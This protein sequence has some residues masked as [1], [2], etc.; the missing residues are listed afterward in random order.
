VRIQSASF[1]FAFNSAL[2]RRVSYP[3]W[4]RQFHPS[5]EGFRAIIQ[6]VHAQAG[7]SL[8]PSF[9]IHFHL[10]PRQNGEAAGALAH[11]LKLSPAERRVARLAAGGDDNADIAKTLGVSLSTVRSHLRNIFHKLGI[12][13]R[14]RLAPLYQAIE[15]EVGPR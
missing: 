4:G 7:R 2:V 8:Q 3:T 11:L 5:V 12:S 13:S 6:L 10:P 1:A 9:G 14:S 15:R